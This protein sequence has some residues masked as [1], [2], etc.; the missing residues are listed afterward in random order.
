MA[1]HAHEPT[2]DE[3]RHGGRHCHDHGPAR[4]RGLVRWLYPYLHRNPPSNRLVVDLAGPGPDDRTLDVGCGPGAAVRAAASVAREAVGVDPSVRMLK[5][6]RRRSRG[7]SN[8]RFVEAPAHKLP[9]G[10][11]EF[12]VAWTVHALH[13]WGDEGAGLA[14]V[15]RILSP[16]GRLLVMEALDP[17]KP[18]GIG[19][20][21]V[22]RISRLLREV[23]FTE[24][25]RSNHASDGFDEVVLTA[26]R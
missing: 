22:D 13:H 9:F 17:G 20:E 18:W 24:V 25:T 19:E 5:I 16:G 21:D 3:H 4:W 6:A 26:T 23:G 15:H 7:H 11:G 10:D 2:H 8:V 1:E 12:D 14:E